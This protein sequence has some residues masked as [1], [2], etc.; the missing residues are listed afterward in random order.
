VEFLGRAFAEP[1]LFELGAAV[2]QVVDGRRPPDGFGP[3]DAG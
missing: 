2:E 1:R 3:V